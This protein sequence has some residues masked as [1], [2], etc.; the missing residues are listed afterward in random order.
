M[1]GDGEAAPRTLGSILVS[2]FVYIEGGKLQRE[3]EGIQIRVTGQEKQSRGE[4]EETTGAEAMR[5]CG[6]LP[7]AG[8]G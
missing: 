8:S 7:V 1:V 6:E 2:K 5:V 4:K 3:G